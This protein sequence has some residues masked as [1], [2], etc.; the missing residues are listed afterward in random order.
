[1]PESKKN[2]VCYSNYEMP[3]ILRDNNTKPG[4]YILVQG[5]NQSD[6]T[7]Y[8]VVKT[9]TGR[10]TAR[11][12]ANGSAANSASYNGRLS[13]RT[14]YSRSKSRST[15]GKNNKRKRSSSKNNKTVKK[16]KL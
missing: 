2:H 7:K 12:V 14:S 16:K 13:N 11:Y 10:K 15:S 6:I 3:E 5:N 8:V 1:M 9:K 4:D